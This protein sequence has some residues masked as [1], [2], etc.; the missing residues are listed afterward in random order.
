MLAHV[1]HGVGTVAL[2]A[3]IFLAGQIFHLQEHWPGGVMLW[4]AGAWL[5]WILLRDRIQGVFCALLT[6]IWLAGE[7][8]EATANMSDRV[9]LVSEGLWLLALVFFAARTR[10]RDGPVRHDLAWIGGL[11]LIP[12]TFWVVLARGDWGWRDRMAIP[13]GLLVF[14][15]IVA[16]GGPVAL[17]FLLRGRGGWV[18]IAAAAW[19]RLFGATVVVRFPQDAPWSWRQISTYVLC[20]AGS[21]LMAWWGVHEAR[22]ERVNLALVA[23]GLTVLSFYFDNVMD[24]LGR[25]ISLM[26]LGLLFLA[27]GYALARMR[28]RLLAGMVEAAP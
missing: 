12:L 21:A 5:A 6:P 7:W 19:I 20:A 1:L 10:D 27:G 2:G 22:R 4:A 13:A 18:V 9:H 8:M 28:R 26:I 23:F 14:G 24:K 17:G 15:W 16:Y 11:T 3:G 25:S